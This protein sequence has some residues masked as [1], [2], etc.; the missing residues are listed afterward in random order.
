MNLWFGSAPFLQRRSTA[1]VLPFLAALNSGCSSKEVLFFRNNPL[2]SIDVLHTIMFTD[3]F[4]I[5]LL[6]TVC[7]YNAKRHEG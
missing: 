1:A 4:V 2:R 7:Y 6:C 5:L 3:K